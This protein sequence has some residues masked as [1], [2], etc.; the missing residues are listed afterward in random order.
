[1]FTFQPDE[2]DGNHWYNV[3][4]KDGGRCYGNLVLLTGAKKWG[5]LMG[6]AGPYLTPLTIEGMIEIVNKL[7][8]LNN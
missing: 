7:K 8:E 6:S 5:F 4:Y 1:M 3:I 2:Y